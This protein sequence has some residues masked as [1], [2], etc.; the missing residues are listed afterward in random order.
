VPECTRLSAP[1]Y[2]EDGTTIAALEITTIPNRPAGLWDLRGEVDADGS[3]EPLQL[4]ESHEYRYAVAVVGLQPAFVQIEPSEVFTADDEGG[5]T[6]RVRPELFTGTLKVTVALSADRT[7]TLRLEVRSKKIDYLRDYRW[8]LRDIAN[9]S[10]ELAMSHF[11]PSEQRFAPDA[12]RDST[13][14]Y[15]RFAF[16]RSIL[17]DESFDA[18]INRILAHPHVAWETA[19]HSRRTAQGWKSGATSTR[20]LARASRRTPAPGL[21]GALSEFGV[22]AILMTAR[23]EPSLNNNANRFVKFAL[24]HWR[25]MAMEM[26]VSLE[27]SF[28]P[29]AERG[30]REVQVVLGKLHILLSEE[31]FRAVEDLSQ[32][33]I[34]DQVIQRRE[35]YRDI[36]YAY[37]LSQVAARLSWAGGNAVYGAG[38]KD[39]ATLY[40]YWAF[41]QLAD[42]VSAACDTGFAWGP[43]VQQSS[44]GADLNLARGKASVLKGSAT[45]LGR[46]MTVELWFNRT[47]GMGGSP[48]A[49]SWSR[50]MRPDC[51][52]LISSGQETG[53]RV[54]SVWIHFDAKYR[55]E[56]LTEIMRPKAMTTDAEVQDVDEMKTAERSG[57]AKSDDLAKMHAYRDA[58]RRSVG[59]YV[60][61]PGDSRELSTEFHEIL[62]GLGAFSL[63]PGLD[64]TAVGSKELRAFIDDV[65]NHLS[66]QIS[67]HERARYWTSRSYEGSPPTTPRYSAASFLVRP[68]A[69]TRVLLG[70]VKDENHFAWIH[71]S[72]LYN[73]RADN[74]TG[75]VGIRS[76]ALASDIVVLYCPSLL[77]VELWA[78]F[79]APEITTRERMLALDYPTPRGEL[80]FC[81]PISENL[82]SAWKDSLTLSQLLTSRTRVAP[83]ASWGEPVSLSW[84]ELIS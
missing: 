40:E 34:N 61:Y 71:R 55:I 43:L 6:G 73:L 44:H 33:P 69:D 63:K 47:F 13:S 67:Q 22:P 3:E 12:S 38:Q 42:V 31:L 46:A 48:S 76:D 14:L 45:R 59:A 20:G 57:T 41:L 15:Q 54:D 70:F 25:D 4:T 1:I 81:L 39:V 72:R 68:P 84:S 19:E 49:S 21:D 58:I 10:A 66:L 65:L 82:T 56:N 74:R 24:V 75:S 83:R 35:G 50:P 62:P 8:M 79:G 23:T 26:L 80:Y 27:H 18:A 11:A 36:Y 16:V 37:L 7:G 2:A 30:V 29:A 32:F 77:R 78:V 52:L 5:R 28:G 60:L 51:S 53:A 9:I 64:E 17:S